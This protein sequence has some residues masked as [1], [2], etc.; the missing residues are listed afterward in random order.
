MQLGGKFYE[1]HVADDQKVKRGDLLI[2]F[3][4]DGIKAAGYKVT[5]PMIVVNTDEYRAVKPLASGEVVAGQDFM[6]VVE[7]E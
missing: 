4:M 3:D 5:T 6:E 2:S 7:K 1:T